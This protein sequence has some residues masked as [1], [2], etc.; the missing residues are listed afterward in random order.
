MADSLDRDIQKL[1]R[2]LSDI[3]KNAVPKADFAAL[4]KVTAQTKSR[5]V[6]DVAGEVKIPQKHIRK[7]VYTKVKVARD[8]RR[9]R[10]TAYRR[11]IPVISLGLVQTSVNR[12]TGI[13][14]LK[15]GGRMYPGAFINQIRKT[16][17]WQVMQRKGAKRYPLEVLTVKIA[18]QV[19]RYLPTRSREIMRAKYPNL[20]KHELTWRLKKYEDKS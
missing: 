9:A 4:R 20:L 2:K 3:S 8:Y 11:D 1:A 10:I 12:R 7:R 13:K 6:K 15:V 14:N 18:P 16:G 19:D 17:Q 5:V